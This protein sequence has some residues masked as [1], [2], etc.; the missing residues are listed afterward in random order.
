MCNISTGKITVSKEIE[1]ANSSASTFPDAIEDIAMGSLSIGR[2]STTS[3]AMSRN[4]GFETSDANSDNEFMSDVSFYTAITVLF[5]LNFKNN[6]YHLLGFGSY[7]STL[8][9]GI[10]KSQI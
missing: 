2:S 6:R 8:R 7:S 5:F 3:L 9:R 1:P 4:F 10:H